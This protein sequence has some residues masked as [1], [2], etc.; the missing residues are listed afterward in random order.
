M[1]RITLQEVVFKLV[2]EGKVQSEEFEALS[3]YYGVDKLRE[4]YK[5][6]MRRRRDRQ[7]HHESQL[8]ETQKKWG[9]KDAPPGDEEWV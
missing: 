2:Q 7:D 3:A 5:R 4:L 6:E 9:T 1:E 8:A